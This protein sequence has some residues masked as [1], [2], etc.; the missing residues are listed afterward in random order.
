M[1]KAS[2][3]SKLS[4]PPAIR[5]TRKDI[6]P[7]RNTGSCA[8]SFGVASAVDR[9]SA[10]A[11]WP[12]AALGHVPT[13]GATPPASSD[14][15]PASLP[16]GGC[17][18]SSSMSGTASWKTK[19]MNAKKATRIKLMEAS[20]TPADLTLKRNMEEF[21]GEEAAGNEQTTGA[22]RASGIQ[23]ARECKT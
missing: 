13:G 14:A 16:G 4:M 3:A 2:N 15:A 23:L 20:T 11:P 8:H 1:G 22:T 17:V 10:Q 6:E 9:T 12:A 21:A 19:G 5:A 18:A 7:A